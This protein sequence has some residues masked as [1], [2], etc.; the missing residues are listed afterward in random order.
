MIVQTPLMTAEDLAQLPEDGWHYELVE[1][2]L[3]Q[4][5]P[6][7]EE[8]G[9]VIFTVTVSLG[10]Y[11]NTHKSGKGY[12]AETGFILTRNPDTVRAP[13]IAFVRQERVQETPVSPSFR[14][15]APDVA[16]EVMSPNDHYTEVDEK[17]QHWLGAGTRMVIVI[18]PRKRQ[19]S[20]HY[21]NTASL[22]L[23]EADTLDGGDV[24]PGWRLPVREIFA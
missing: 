11:I 8:H 18:N 1:G 9:G 21:P 2:V 14:R 4:M 10:N 24:L 12:G 5:A 22:L 6:A 7:G 13:D 16:I 17:V 3:H 19:V 23:T 20:V 15:G